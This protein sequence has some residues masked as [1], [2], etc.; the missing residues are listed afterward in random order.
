MVWTVRD[1]MDRQPSALAETASLQE[2]LEQL[3]RD[4]ADELYVTDAAGRL[5]GT[6]PDFELLKAAMNG[7]LGQCGVVGLM[8]RAVATVTGDRPVQQVAPLFRDGRCRQMAVLEC[9]RLVGVLHRRAVLGCLAGRLGLDEERR[10][11]PPPHL[12][13]MGLPQGREAVAAG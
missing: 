8:S 10:E 5:L 13:R 2:A 6:V 9:S 4:R 12:R 11:C 7:T 3:W 1:V